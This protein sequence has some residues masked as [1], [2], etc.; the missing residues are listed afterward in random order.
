MR[1]LTIH[2]RYRQ[3]GGE[4]VSYAREVAL[5]R[6]KGDEVAEYVRDNDELDDNSWFDWLRMPA[7][8]A[9]SPRSYREV[10]RVIDEFR[11]DV[12]HFHNTFVAVSPSAYYACKERGVPVVQSLHNPRFLC[13]SANLYRRG[14]LC[15]DCVGR[16]FAWPGVIHSCY[17]NSAVFS[18][19]V[20]WLTAIHR[21]A[22][23]WD[24]LIDRYV[25]FTKF[26]QRLFVDAGLPADKI[27]VKPHFLPTDPGEREQRAYGE[28]ALYVGRLEPE[29]GSLTLLDA[30]RRVGDIPLVVRGDG[31]L[32]H[33][34]EGARDL[35]SSGKLTI[36]GKI[37]RSEL[38]TMLKG[39]RFLIWPSEG[40]Y[41]TFGNIAMEAMACGTPILASSTGVAPEMVT[42]G[43]TG[44]LFRPG[45][46]ADLAAKAMSAWNNPEETLQLG[47]RGRR[48]FEKRFA[49]DENYDQ[50][51]QIYAEA[52]ATSLG[53]RAVQHTPLC[54]ADSPSRQRT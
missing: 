52:R 53:R 49:A 8:L 22:G 31:D 25:V 32:L 54:T 23:T 17:R 48:E 33:E 30:W 4:D 27:V 1:I 40:F 19:G 28:Y 3:S 42:D 20:A 16:N 9:W 21:F 45:D 35:R 44:M 43:V 5:L 7:T 11:P 29:K 37:P 36:V 39:A 41:E 38:N 14:S 34:Y 6:E 15:T 26:Y 10:L 2:N 47:I 13:P 18:M 50:L 24:K 12:A 51:Q 46:A